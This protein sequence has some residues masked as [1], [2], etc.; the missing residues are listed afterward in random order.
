MPRENRVPSGGRD[1]SGTWDCPALSMSQSNPYHSKEAICLTCHSVNMNSCRA[2]RPKISISYQEG[3]QPQQQQQK[4][5]N[6]KYLCRYKFFRI[7]LS[8]VPRASA[9]VGPSPM[10]LKE[11]YTAHPMAPRSVTELCNVQSLQDYINHK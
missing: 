1:E 8:S 10:M 9:C 2:G 3:K 5:P 11:R 7:C 6:N 4:E